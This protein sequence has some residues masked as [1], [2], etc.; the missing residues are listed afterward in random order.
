MLNEFRNPS[1]E[2]RPI[3]FWSWNEDLKVEELEHQIEEMSKAGL[4][5]YFM[6]ARSGLKIDYLGKE[7]FDC[8]EAGIKKGK[9]CELDAWIYDEEGWPSGF[10][11]GIVTAMSS[12]YH[13][14]FME[15][16]EYANWDDIDI[17]EMLAIYLLHEDRS[18]ERITD[19]V[20]CGNKE[21]LL[22]VRR[23][24]QQHY[25]DVMNKAA[26]DAFL[27]VTHQ[28]YYE[29]Y[30][31]YFGKEMQGFFTDE[32]RFTCNK[33][34]I[35]AW[36]DTIPKEFLS[37][38][39]YELIDFLPLLWREYAGYEKVRYDFWRAANDMFVTNYMKN[40]YDWCEEHNCKATG[41]IMM[42]ET[43]FSQMTSS[44]GVMPFYEYE[45]IPGIDW[46]R[47]RIESPVIGK[48]VGSVACQLGKKK[49]IT[50]SFALTGWNVSFEELKWIYEWQCV[51]GVNMLCQHLEAYSLK[52]SRKRDYPPSLFVQQSWWKEYKKFNDY[53][54]RLGVA[55]S[56]GDQMADVLLLHP[57]RS[58][59]LCF[60]GT[61]TE[62]IKILDNKFTEISNVLSAQHVSYHYGDETIISRH[63]G[64]RDKEFVVGKIGYKT[65]ILPHMYSIDVVTLKLLNE[66]IVRGG[67]VLSVGKFP[68]YTNGSYEELELL[69]KNTRAVT[70]QEILPSMKKIGLI[71][72]SIAC[73]GKQVE[74]I[75]YQQRET[76]EGIV[77]FMVNH[78]QLETYHPDIMVY[79]KSTSVQL[80]N[81]ETGELLDIDYIADEDTTFSLTFEPMQSYLVLLKSSIEKSKAIQ[82]EDGIE[83][84][85]RSSWD[86]KEMGR[87][88][89]TLDLCTYRIDDGELQGP[90]PAIKL[91]K[92]LLNLKRSCQIEI[93]YEFTVEM[94]LSNNKMFFIAMEDAER[95]T[96]IINGH[97]I[98]DAT[99]GYWKDQSFKKVD[100]KPYVKNGKNEVLLKGIFEQDKKVYDTLFGENV[101]ETE[102]N[103]L[104]F[105]MEIESIYLV[106]DFGVYS[107]APF[108]KTVRNA[109]FT[110]GPFVITDKPTH[111]DHNNFTTQ[112]LLFFAEELTIVQKVNI[113]KVNIHKEDRKRIIFNYQKQN[114]PMIQIWVNG[115]LVKTSLWAPYQVDI[116]E[117]S[118]DGENELEIHL[119]AS[120][121]NLLGPHHHSKGE[122]YNVG[123]DSFTG[124][125]SWVERESEAEA[126]DITDRTKNYW[127]EAYCF[128]DFGLHE[129]NDVK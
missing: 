19:K 55:L 9:E 73:N 50:E 81:A 28:Q 10:A 95:Y 36:S 6:H 105:D 106:G 25:I 114:A 46:L 70:Y 104:T 112:G 38:Y 87:N 52:G 4:G 108:E 96:T 83:V 49:V 47:R 99:D 31:D 129:N 127:N 110:E 26:V 98:S 77:L 76:E 33:I 65:V 91:M 82:K 64:V 126:T 13:A 40:I 62:S 15:L 79:G 17:D 5:G 115:K 128:V 12:D 61:R 109:M 102:L 54:G 103:K 93:G 123:P 89:L 59:Y 23:K 78:S 85:I 100:I 57:M 75:A 21:M 90:V 67:T 32:P 107:K 86:V 125:W 20:I 74:N 39:E 60:D 16:E 24:V 1:K 7:W 14:K 3:P 113:H 58:G 56:S 111:F 124:K 34:G 2:F 53:V 72:V 92:T 122:C 118:I 18:F 121:R 68:S 71:S 119:Y 43:I 63:G 101:Y 11:G 8:I 97:M 120:N 84:A 22:A 35:L 45:H 42:E 116:T 27:S 80:M 48:Q 30:G 41:H 69:M 117:E 66:F 51:N 29:K 88:S 37:R 94:N 44:A